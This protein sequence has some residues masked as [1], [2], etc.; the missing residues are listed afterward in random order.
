MKNISKKNNCRICWQ[1]L[2]NEPILQYRNMPAV[3]QY[4]PNAA[5]LKKDKGVNLDIY[6]CSGCGTVQLA[7]EPVSYYKEVIRATGVSEEMKNFRRQQFLDFIKSH[8]LVGKKIIEIGCG[9]GEYLSIMSPLGATAYGL[10]D[11]VESVK[12]CQ[13]NGLSVFRGFV[14]REDYKI[15]QSPFAAFFMLSFLEHLPDPVAALRGIANNLAASA[16]GLVEVPNFDMILKKNL[17]SEFMRDHLFYFTAETLK[18]T[19]EISGFK[20]LNCEQVWHDYIISA[21]VVKKSRAD[22][23]SLKQHQEKLQ[24]VIEEYLSKFDGK[25]VAI[26]GAGHQALAIMAMFNLTDKIK[27]VVDSADF[28]QGKYTPVTHLPI[29]SP[30]VLKSDPVDGIIVMA[31]SY[32]DEVVKIIREK[33]FHKLPIVVVKDFGLIE[34]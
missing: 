13:K 26:W 12:L 6:Q 1:P 22:V 20:V 10:D 18:F 19:L 34:Y 29:V 32:S 31:G 7:N 28:K 11:S 23:S 24:K 9:R 17:F 2:F 33:Y 5:D 15:E 21:T 14:D 30:D 27:Y 3:A 8:Q 25:K 4:L 16:V